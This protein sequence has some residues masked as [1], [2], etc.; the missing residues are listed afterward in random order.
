MSL[1]IYV[2]P[3][4]RLTPLGRRLFSNS[5]ERYVLLGIFTT[6]SSMSPD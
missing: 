2:V 5:R 3:A 6:R 1:D 4:E